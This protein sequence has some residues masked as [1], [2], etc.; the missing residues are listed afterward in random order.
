M[1]LDVDMIIDGIIITIIDIII[2]GVDMID[3]GVRHNAP[4]YLV[5]PEILVSC[6]P[7]RRFPVVLPIPPQVFQFVRV[8]SPGA[9]VPVLPPQVLQFVRVPS[10][11]AQSFQSRP[12]FYNLSVSRL[13]ARSP[14]N[15]APGF[16]TCPCP[17]CWRVVLPIPPQV[18]QFVRVPSPDA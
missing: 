14:S 11:G 18:L 12:R 9:Y 15:S 1:I 8:P 17:V 6:G 16:S 2:L 13:L 3:I 4:H 10:A 5:T 7:P